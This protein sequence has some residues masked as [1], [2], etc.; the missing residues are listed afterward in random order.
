MGPLPDTAL[1]ATVKLVKVNFYNKLRYADQDWEDMK[2]Q[3]K[4]SVLNRSLKRTSRMSKPGSSEWEHDEISAFLLSL[5]DPY[6]RHMPK[7]RFGAKV[8]DR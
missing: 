6:T 5:Q 3:A 8:R 2:I 4:E 7:S 1:D